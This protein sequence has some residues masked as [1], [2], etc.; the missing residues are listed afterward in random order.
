MRRSFERGIGPGRRFSA[1]SFAPYASPRIPKYWRALSILT[2]SILA[3]GV[4]SCS[5][6][7]PERSEQGDRS[8]VEKAK[9]EAPGLQG[10]S[11]QPTPDSTI[12]AIKKR[13][14]LRVGMQ[15]GYVP[16][17]M[18]G[19]GGSLTG[20]D[21]D[22]AELVARDLM[23]QVK[24]VRGN[25]QEL[26]PS[27]LNGETDVIMSGMTVTSSR[28]TEVLFT[29]PV[30]ETGRMFL[31]H[32]SHAS[33]FK[34]FKDLN[35]QGVF[36]VSGPSGL[37]TLSVREVLPNASYREFP[38]RN[39]A[40]E[41]V[42]QNRAHALIDE[43]FFIRYASA[44]QSGSLIPRFEPITYER[45]AWAVRPGDIHWLNWLNNFIGM[46]RHNGRMDE[47]RKKWLHDYFLDIRPKRQSN[48]VS[49]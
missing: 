8:I 35:Q 34:K 36:I 23:V 32:T 15:V 45:I 47:L 49:P 29:E 42:L 28:N 12:A 24:I 16:F 11:S 46:A 33:R 3:F 31:V 25:W 41:E 10:K 27:L 30:L 43:E 38:D 40:L 2:C 9:H 19:P 37:G 13:G 17:E 22:A 6:P 4:F 14:E 44:S 26:I 48:E 21:V 39:G 5:W 7:D 20:F 1:K 18:I